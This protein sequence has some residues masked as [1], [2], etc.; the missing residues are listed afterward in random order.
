[1]SEFTLSIDHVLDSKPITVQGDSK[2]TAE[3]VCMHVCK[4]LNISPL[5]RTLFALRVTNKSNPNKNI[6]LA[7]CDTFGERTL[8]L[9]FRIRFKVADVTKLSKIDIHAYDYYF[10]QVRKDVLENKIPG[11]IYETCKRELLGLGITDMYRVMLEKEIPKETLESQ[12]RK[13][14]P[15]EVWRRHAF[16]TKKPIRDNLR[17]LESAIEKSKHNAL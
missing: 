10:H 5:T 17:L 11:L 3:D 6:F 15:K 4:Q 9:D 14:V 8:V 12:Y 2:I 13:Y 16:F 7:P 1:M